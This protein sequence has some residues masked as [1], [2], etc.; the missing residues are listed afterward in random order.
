MRSKLRRYWDSAC[1]FGYLQNQADRAEA[2]ERVLRDAERGNCEI[3]IS[4]LTI[5]EVLHL[6]GDKR[7]FPA[8]SRERIRG[9]FRRDCFVVAD[10]DR[11]IAEAAQEIFWTHDIQPKDAVH[12][13]TALTANVHFFETY[14]GHLI[15][16]SRLLG[17]DPQLVV[18]EP[19]TDL[20]AREAAASRP[21][22]TEFEIDRDAGADAD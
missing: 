5:A 13:A 19:G 14:D 8:S 6:K 3:V 10:V 2:C 22:Q 18:H 17:G 21:P 15:G 11:F 20:V 1:C 16:K 4:A 12:L 7:A 9:F